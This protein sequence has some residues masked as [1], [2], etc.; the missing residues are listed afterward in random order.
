[1]LPTLYPLYPEF[2]DDFADG[3]LHEFW[4]VTGNVAE[5]GGVLRM[6]QNEAGMSQAAVYAYDG[7]VSRFAADIAPSFNAPA[8][9]DKAYCC[10]VFGDARVIRWGKMRKAA[11]WELTVDDD[12]NIVF[13]EATDDSEARFEIRRRGARL[14]FGVVVNDEFTVKH[15]ITDW[16]GAAAYSL[17]LASEYDAGTCDFD[18]A[19]YVCESFR[20]DHLSSRILGQHLKNTICVYGAGFLEGAT[21]TLDGEACTVTVVSANELMIVTPLCEVEAKHAELRVSAFYG[22]LPLIVSDCV[23]SGTGYRIL[24]GLLP[25]ERYTDDPANLFNVRLAA[26]GRQ[27]DQLDFARR[28]LIEREIFPQ[29]ADAL[30]Y[31]HEQLYSIATNLIDTLAVRRARV[32][33]RSL[34]TPRMN[35]AFLNKIVQAVL[36]GVEITENDS[37]TEYGDLYWQAQIYEPAS[38]TLDSQTYGELYQALQDAAGAWTDHQIGAAGF[39]VGVSAVGRDF[40]TAEE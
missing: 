38:N 27:L 12:E 33:M 24:R 30:L 4:S 36:P 13:T 18:D 11:G 17:L 32:L 31:R 40:L 19:E 37:Y 5:T 1:M 7:L 25:P 26:R 29:Y 23:I 39:T 21:A 2:S 3:S 16:S 10:V 8:G 20:V 6:T 14:E 35:L 9:G 15:V 28:A 22:A 34:F